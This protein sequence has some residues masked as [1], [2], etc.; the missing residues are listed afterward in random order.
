MNFSCPSIDSSVYLRASVIVCL[1]ERKSKESNKKEREKE[2]KQKF[3][4]NKG[5]YSGALN[6]N[7]SEKKKFKFNE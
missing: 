1:D 5:L 7:D 2:R 6:K 3:Q 4:N